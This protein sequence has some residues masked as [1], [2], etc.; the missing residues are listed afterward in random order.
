MSSQ[1]L[2][3]LYRHSGRTN[4]S[5]VIRSLSS[6]TDEQKPSVGFI[7]KFIGKDTNIA[8]P[9]F[10]KRWLMVA[11]AFFTHMCI[12]SPFGWS[13]MAD[14]I[15]REFGV[16]ASSSGDWTLMNAALPLS[17]VFAGNGISAALMGKWQMK[18]GPR[19]AIAV[20]GS[21]FGGGLLLGSLGIY[22]HSLPLLYGG[23]GCLAGFGIGL[24][25]TPP[26]QTLMNW[27]PD[28]KGLASGLVLGGF[29]GGAMVFTPL[30]Q[31]LTKYFSKKP[32][33]L[34]SFDD[35]VT[36]VID[37]KL[38]AS[39]G[40]E[41]VEVVQ[42]GAA[43]LAKLPYSI[44]EGLYVVGS[45]ST[46]AAEA[47]AVLGLGYFSV[48]LGSALVIKSPHA[49]VAPKF[50]PPTAAAVTPPVNAGGD[51]EVTVSSATS[52]YEI[53]F[54]D[55]MRAPQFYLLGLTFFCLSGGGL[56][57]FSV[58]K[59]MMSEVFSK[60]VP[61]IVTSAFASKFVLMLSA[62]N[63]GGR[64]AWAAFSDKVGRRATFMLLTGMSIPI[65]MSLPTIVDQVI[66]TQSSVPLYLFCAGTTAA[67]TMMGGNFS[68]MPAYEADLFGAKYIGAIH[69]R[70]MFFLGAA[71]LSGPYLV[72]KLRAMSEKAA[73]MDLIDKIPATD[74][75]KVFG[76]PVSQATELIETKVVTISRL[77][78]MVPPEVM[79]PSPHLYDSSMYALSGAMGIAT[80]AHFMVKPLSTKQIEGFI[81]SSTSKK[82]ID[83]TPKN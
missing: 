44:A 57:L 32:E 76:S 83:V 10:D 41:M 56:G 30:V 28:K 63:L 15:T 1:V 17:I 37:G 53:T 31:K 34:G 75:E 69:G 68:V 25:Y 74:F 51:K 73:I 13:V 65:Y 9:T 72:L 38:M 40:G 50:A 14:Q 54:D 55:A 62:G 23:Y 5:P 8:S 82:V 2:R 3:K 7:D 11:P 29:G 27:F 46:G 26:I 48:M 33:F 45:G 59:P 43:E 12:G 81:A 22:L 4:F 39:R 24:A 19:K 20:A 42:C 18:V 64:L 16:V 61:A 70:M 6:Q 47:L 49:S 67:V 60:A 58:A 52:S 80:V 77:M 35:T 71:S 79:D 78:T 36:E 66:T 21:C